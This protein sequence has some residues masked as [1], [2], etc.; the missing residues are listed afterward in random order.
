MEVPSGPSIITPRG[1]LKTPVPTA[2]NAPGPAIPNITLL[3]PTPGTGS[4]V[5]P[6]RVPSISAAGPSFTQ[7]Q[8]VIPGPN[9]AQNTTVS[10]QQ[11]LNTLLA[12]PSLTS[13]TPVIPVSVF[14]LP[15]SQ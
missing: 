13:G 9:P 14:A 5:V 3:T 10:L 11:L 15:S 12:S 2:P 4:L 8:L 1:G 6:L 7:L